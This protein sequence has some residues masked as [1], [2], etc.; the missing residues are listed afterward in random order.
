MLPPTA[1]AT[2]LLRLT[3]VHKR[4]GGVT[5]LDGVD[6]SCRRGSIHAVLG[7]NG[8]GKSTLIK[9]V[10]GAVRPDSGHM[11]VD[12]QPVHFADPLDA[13]RH[14]FVCVFQE[15][16]LLPDLSVAD[17]ISITR[18]PGL[19]GFINHRAQRR[20]AEA[21]LA[22]VGCGD[23]D[24]R[25]TVRDLSLS[26]RQLVEFA[27]A[28]GR[29]PRVLIMDEATS[30]LTAG[31]VET[32]NTLLRALPTRARL[33]CSSRIACMRSMRWPIPARCSVAGVTSKRSRR[34]VAPNMTSST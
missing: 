5:A 26:R 34:A 32:V 4:Y 10:A 16:S 24:P 12:G 7:E 17:N 11:E 2:P 27:K 21:L 19:A 22:R 31:D 3:G 30:A 23:I 28:L 13:V 8:A 29:A 25:T 1:A 18:P 14:G 6:F 15:L 9:I 20:R 33:S